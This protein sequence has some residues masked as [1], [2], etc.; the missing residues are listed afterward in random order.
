MILLQQAL[1]AIGPLDGAAAEA[2]K[3]RQDSLT[4]PKGSLGRLEEL[5]IQ[6]AGITGKTAPSLAKKVIFVMAADHGVVEEGVSLFPQDVTAQMVKNFLAGGA[7]INALARQAGARVVVTD[8]GVR[9]PVLTHPALRVRRIADGTGNIARGPAMSRDQA[10]RCI[11]AGISAVEEES[12]EG[13][14]I[15]GTGD[16]GIGNTT[17]STAIAVAFTGKPILEVTGRGTGLDDE[18]LARKA[19]VV[20]RALKVNAPDSRDPLDVLAKVGGFEIGA[21]AGVILAAAARRIPAVIDGFISGAAAL[22]AFGLEPKVKQYLIASH[23]SVERG[24]LAILRYIGLEPYLDLGLRL[25]EGTGA[26]LAMILADAAVRVISGMATFA[27][28]GVS[29]SEADGE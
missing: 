20:E 15:L 10:V 6:L 14:D 9:G 8:V 17:P 22:L 23:L 28:A 27:E 7:G 11:E 3:Q 26:A 18:G 24:H 19:R 25:G 13:I 4:K 5:S 29:G 2:A 12:A 1:R 16:M 21:L